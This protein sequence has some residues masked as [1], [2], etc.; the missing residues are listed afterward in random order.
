MLITVEIIY[1]IQKKLGLNFDFFVGSW[2]SAFKF[3]LFIYT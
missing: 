1:A 2:S 3:T